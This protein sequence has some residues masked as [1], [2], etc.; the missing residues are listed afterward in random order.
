MLPGLALV[1]LVSVPLTTHAGEWLKRRVPADPLVNRHAGLGGTLLPWA[2]ALFA[3]TVAVWWSGRR[4][5]FASETA[6]STGWGGGTAILRV[7]VRVVAIVLSLV[8]GVGSVVRV[9]RIGDSGAQA[10]WHDSFSAQP[11][12]Q[13]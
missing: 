10:V 8:V 1:A 6:R 13:G 3:V 11:V 2:I 12:N 7:P 9:Y 4:A 5:P